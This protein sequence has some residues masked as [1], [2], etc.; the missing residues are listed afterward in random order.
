LEIERVVYPKS[1]DAATDVYVAGETDT[2]RS[3]HLLIRRQADDAEVVAAMRMD[4][5][6][7][8][9]D[10]TGENAVRCIMYAIKDPGGGKRALG[11]DDSRYCGRPTA[12]AKHCALL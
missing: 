2:C 10:P 7:E 6:I 1:R 12:W 9:G 5:M 8:R 11:S 3:A 4:K